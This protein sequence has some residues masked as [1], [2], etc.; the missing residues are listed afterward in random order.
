MCDDRLIYNTGSSLPVAQTRYKYRKR[1]HK[2]AKQE[3]PTQR[4]KP[5]SVSHDPKPVV[6]QSNYH[7]LTTMGFQLSYSTS[8]GNSFSFL[9]FPD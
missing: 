9:S 8:I 1:A 4:E 5:T 2:R 3:K 6:P 7:T